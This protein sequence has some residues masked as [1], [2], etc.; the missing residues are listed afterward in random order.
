MIQDPEPELPTHQPGVPQPPVLDVDEY[1][2]DLAELQLTPEQE[3]ELLECMW[4]IVKMIVDSQLGLDA[5]SNVLS[6]VARKIF[7]GDEISN[8]NKPAA[9]GERS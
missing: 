5:T 3:R 1:R 4:E 6:A 9:E 2:A 8:D 7:L